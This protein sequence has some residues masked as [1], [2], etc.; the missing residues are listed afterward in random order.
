MVKEEILHTKAASSHTQFQSCPLSDSSF[1]FSSRSPPPRLKSRKGMEP[2]KE[3]RGE[4]A[5]AFQISAIHPSILSSALLSLLQ[6][7]S[8]PKNLKVV[9]TS[10]PE[11][12]HDKLAHA[13]FP[14]PISPS[15]IPFPSSTVFLTG[16][17]QEEPVRGAVV[18]DE[19]DLDAF[20]LPQPPLSIPPTVTMSDAC[21][22][23]PFTWC[24]LSQ[25]WEHSY[26]EDNRLMVWWQDDSSD[27]G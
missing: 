2:R 16:G 22:F 5:L 10:L 15:D 13:P 14:S 11:E 20:S 18:K 3:G 4:E 9:L 17:K 24:D 8:V 12:R 26:E 6:Q 7:S 1:S 23:L 27:Y 19:V 21:S 25:S